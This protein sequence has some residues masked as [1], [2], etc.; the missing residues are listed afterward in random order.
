VVGA[1]DGVSF[2]GEVGSGAPLG[3]GDGSDGL[4]VKEG[5]PVFV[6]DCE[7]V[8]DGE[9]VLVGAGLVDGFGRGVVVGLGAGGR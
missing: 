8:V 5:P 3:V 7:G 2:G 9:V 1:Y 6:C 4:G